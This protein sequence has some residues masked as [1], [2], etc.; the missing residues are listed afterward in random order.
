[1]NRINLL[2]TFAV[3][4]LLP[5]H[6]TGKEVRMVIGFGTGFDSTVRLNDIG[7]CSLVGHCDVHIVIRRQSHLWNRRL[8]QWNCEDMDV[9]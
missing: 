1:M 3:F 9:S 2:F 8:N 7:N 5:V 6:I 4:L